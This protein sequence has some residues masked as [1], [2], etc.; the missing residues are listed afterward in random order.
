MSDSRSDTVLQALEWVEGV[1]GPL[2]G[3]SGRTRWA[4]RATRVDAPRCVILPLWPQRP[5]RSTEANP[6]NRHVQEGRERHPSLCEFD[7]LVS[8][9]A[10]PLHRW[11][12]KDVRCHCLNGCT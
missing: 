9:F 6:G 1:G 12:V 4:S 8:G 10:H 7:T 5:V 3:P 2:P 11:W